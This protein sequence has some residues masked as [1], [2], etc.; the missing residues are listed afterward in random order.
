[1]FYIIFNAGCGFATSQVQL[2]FLRLLA[3]LAAAGPICL[4]QLILA[5][6][7][8]KPARGTPCCL[9]ALSVVV[10]PAIGNVLGG[11]ENFSHLIT[12]KKPSPESTRKTLFSL[13]TF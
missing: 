12:L 6:M 4:S 2:F 5:E 13:V 10:G 11:L 8:G 1:M 9:N 7:W 3:G